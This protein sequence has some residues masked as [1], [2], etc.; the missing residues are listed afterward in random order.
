MTVLRRK[1]RQILHDGGILSK[2]YFG[3]KVANE[4]LLKYYG[5]DV[6]Q[7]VPCDGSSVSLMEALA[8]LQALV[9]DIPA[10]KEW[11][12]QDVNGWIYPDGNIKALAQ[13]MLDA[14]ETAFEPM[15][16]VARNV[17]LSKADWRKNVQMLYRCYKEVL[18]G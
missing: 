14:V 15:K 13:R 7:P 4:D 12:W 9:S 11:V 1:D 5:A 8:R 18:N 17:A 6:C 2:V 3:D 16:I 10:N